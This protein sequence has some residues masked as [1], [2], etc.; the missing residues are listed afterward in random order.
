VIEGPM[1]GMR[2]TVTRLKNANRLVLTID[3]I[4]QSVSVE[5]DESSLKKVK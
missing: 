5:V 2:G 3:G 4:M 1:R